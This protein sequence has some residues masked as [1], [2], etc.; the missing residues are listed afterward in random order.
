M[1]AVC[2]S[3][4]GLYVAAGLIDGQVFIYE[5]ADLKY[6]TQIACIRKNK[7]LK[8]SHDKRKVTGVTFIYSQ[9]YN[10]S[11]ENSR[12]TV[13]TKDK[14]QLLVTTNDSRIRLFSMTDFTLILKLKGLTNCSRQIKATSSSD[15]KNVICGSDT[16]EVFLW[17]ILQQSDEKQSSHD[18]LNNSLHDTRNSSDKNM[19]VHTSNHCDI[20]PS[21]TKS[22]I[23]SSSSSSSQQIACTSAIF[24]PIKSIRHTLNSRETDLQTINGLNQPDERNIIALLTAEYDGS[25]HILFA[26]KDDTTISPTSSKS[27]SSSSLSSTSTLK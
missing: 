22:Q 20:I 19:I 24:I 27:V 21:R 23:P 5:S 6:Y 16:G 4:D 2:F 8:S 18:V 26:Q 13:L 3:P 10:T 7:K 25:I 9:K 15:G 14:Y 17:K 1:T 12:R 11:N